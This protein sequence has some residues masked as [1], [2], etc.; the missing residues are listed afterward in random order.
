MLWTELSTVR[1][2]HPTGDVPATTAVLSIP[3]ELSARF[4]PSTWLQRKNLGHVLGFC[5]KELLHNR[6]IESVELSPVFFGQGLEVHEEVQCIFE[7]NSHRRTDIITINR[8]QQKDIIID[9]TICMERDLNQAYQPVKGLTDQ[10]AAGL[11][12]TCEAEVDDHPTRMEVSWG[13][14]DDHPSLIAGITTRIL[15]P[16]CSPSASRCWMGTVFISPTQLHMSPIILSFLDAKLLAHWMTFLQGLLKPANSFNWEKECKKGLFSD[17][18]AFNSLA[19]SIFRHGDRSPVSSYPTDPYNNVSYWPAGWGQLT[20]AGKQ[21]Q[22]ELGQW[23]RKRYSKFLPEMYN[24]EDIFVRSTDVDRTLMSAESNLAG[25]YPPRQWQKWSANISWQPI[26]IHT[27]PENMDQCSPFLAEFSAR[28]VAV[29]LAATRQKLLATCWAFVGKES[30]CITGIIESVEL[31][32]VFFGTRVGKFMKRIKEYLKKIKIS[33]NIEEEWN[34]LT[35]ILKRAAFESIG[36]KNIK[37]KRKRGILKW[38]EDIKKMINDKREACLR[39]L[40]T[41]ELEDEIDYKRKRA[42]AKWETRKRHRE[43]W[44]DFVSRLERDLTLPRP[45]TFKILKKINSEIKE[46]VVINPIPNEFLLDYFKNIWFQKNISLTLQ[47]SNNNTTDIITYD[48]LIEVLAGERPCPRYNAEMERVKS[49]PEMKRFNEEHAELY[50]YISEK[51]GAVVHDP[52]SLEYIYNT[53]FIEDLYNLTLP[54]WTKEVYPDKMKPV[55]SFSFTVPA[56]TK[57]LQRL[58][59]GPLMGE[60]VKHMIEK[61]DGVLRPNYK[62]FM[63]SGHDVTIANFLMALGVFDPQSPPYRA[64]IMVEL[65]KTKQGKH[66]VMVYFRNSTAHEPYNLIIPGCQA[67]CP[68]DDFARLLKPVI[69][70]NWEKECKKGLFSDDFAFNSLAIIALMVSGILAVLLLLSM[71]FGITYWKKQRMSSNYYY[72]RLHQD[73]S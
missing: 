14:H 67:A 24:R 17:D 60:M 48:E 5:R 51:S 72:H 59:I 36:V 54:N 56:K 12:P 6:I 70:F 13:K 34:N 43:K 39:F 30:Y 47:T 19:L 9:P 18:F 8:Q 62:M 35:D 66:K 26:P 68:L 64:L 52:E 57:L 3:A 31:S 25:L 63:Y 11:T 44:N 33:D 61:R 50:K 65:W 49:S 1:A 32:P 20:N 42:I 21:Q 22:Y 29:N 10:L 15:L 53:L 23:L 28:L 16:I 37:Q 71:V 4:L 73:V 55:A 46:N 45:K 69:P 27:V 7:D 40:Q 58:K 38:D 2:H 41:K